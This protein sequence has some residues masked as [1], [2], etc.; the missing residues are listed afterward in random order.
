MNAYQ[1]NKEPMSIRMHL[2][3]MT[4]SFE[5]APFFANYVVFWDKFY[6]VAKDGFKVTALPPYPKFC[7]QRYGLLCLTFISFFVWFFCIYDLTWVD[8]CYF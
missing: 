6:S 3:F 5:T 1:F 8:I 4:Q 7:E 2:A